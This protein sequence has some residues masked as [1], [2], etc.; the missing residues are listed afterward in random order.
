MALEAV[1]VGQM[2]PA[3][4]REKALIFPLYQLFFSSLV[5]L[6][7]FSHLFFIRRVII[8]SFAALCGP[9]TVNACA[10]ARW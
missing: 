5:P 9:E 8:V 4:N 2:K 7:F 1:V 6:L 10:D 3:L